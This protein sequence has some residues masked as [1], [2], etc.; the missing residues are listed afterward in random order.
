MRR[1]RVKA[2]RLEKIIKKNR[3][4]LIIQLL[5]IV[6]SKPGCVFVGK[7]KKSENQL[8][9]CSFSFSEELTH[10]P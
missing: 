7:N 8:C 9:V 10:A 2:R 5:Y 1:R 3:E 6:L 4:T